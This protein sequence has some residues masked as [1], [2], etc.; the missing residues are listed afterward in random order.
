M[1]QVPASNTDSSSARISYLVIGG[2]RAARHTSHYLKLES[3]PCESWRREDGI[4]AL[5]ERF[6]RASH[7]LLL[8]SDRAIE[9]FVDAHSWLLEKPVTHFSGALT[10]ARVAGAH[11][12]M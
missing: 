4:D 3:V 9:S 2:G 11:P 8:I 12:L 5:R 6:A 10:S 1:R 7:V